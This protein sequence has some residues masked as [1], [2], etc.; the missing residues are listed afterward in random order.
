MNRHLF[1]M[2]SALTEKRGKNIGLHE[3][4]CTIQ[5]VERFSLPNYS[6]VAFSVVFELC[7][8]YVPDRPTVIR[9]EQH[10]SLASWTKTRLDVLWSSL[11]FLKISVVRTPSPQEKMTLQAHV[12]R[13][14]FKKNKKFEW[15][16][17][18]GL[19]LCIHVLVQELQQRSNIRLSETCEL[20]T[21]ALRLIFFVQKQVIRPSTGV[22]DFAN[23]AWFCALYFASATIL[24]RDSF[25]C[26][27][28]KTKKT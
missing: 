8:F 13:F 27:T 6:S 16:F 4:L 28:N 17:N 18:S 22:F 11:Q 19:L 7:Q 12:A 9:Q 1:P 21:H 23:T 10:D 15:I 5:A 25:K 20:M 14:V 24:P 3:C 26:H 2:T